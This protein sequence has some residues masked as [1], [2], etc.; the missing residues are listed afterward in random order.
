LTALVRCGLRSFVYTTGITALG[1]NFN[2]ANLYR[3][4]AI[5]GLI[6]FGE[7]NNGWSSCTGFKRR[8][9]RASDPIYSCRR[10]IPQLLAANETQRRCDCWWGFLR[11]HRRL[12]TR[13]EGSAEWV[14]YVPS[15]EKALTNRQKSKNRWPTPNCGSDNC[16]FPCIK[17]SSATAWSKRQSQRSAGITQTEQSKLVGARTWNFDL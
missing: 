5:N 6:H 17:I 4:L 15:E 3:S 16:Y 9:A 11:D 13:R 2:E 8:E 1:K 10:H 14:R 7:V 12:A